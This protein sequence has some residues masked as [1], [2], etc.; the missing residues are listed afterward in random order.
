LHHV[1]TASRLLV[2]LL[3]LLLLVGA[4]VLV[5]ITLVTHLRLVI[6][7]LASAWSHH[8]VT[9]KLLLVVLLLA[10]V[11]VTHWLIH[12]ALHLVVVS[13]LLVLVHLGKLTRTLIHCSV[14]H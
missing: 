5:D 3:L 9:S 11:R 10:H 6:L 13:E 14:H 4:E 2:V 7:L 1:E 12:L 8:I